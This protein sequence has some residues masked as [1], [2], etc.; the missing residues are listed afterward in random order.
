MP[1]DYFIA[2]SLPTDA[3]GNVLIPEG[4]RSDVSFVTLDAEPDPSWGLH[5]LVAHEE[6]GAS[7]PWVKGLEVVEEDGAVVIHADDVTFR[8]HGP[9]PLGWALVTE[10]A[11]IAYGSA[12]RN[13]K[14]VS[15][16]QDESG[17]KTCRFTWPPGGIR[18]VVAAPVPDDL[19]EVV[20]PGDPNQEAS[21]A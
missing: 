7:N 1:D 17:A 3:D 6:P 18:L 8:H 14:L 16:K 13:V 2:A 11:P 4:V 5:D 9:R 15:K 19:V 21:P 10:G 12:K 20:S